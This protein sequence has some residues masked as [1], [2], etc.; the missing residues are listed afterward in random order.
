[1]MSER[2]IVPSA[3]RTPRAR[4]EEP[5]RCARGSRAA[6]STNRCHV[7]FATANLSDGWY[8]ITSP[9]ITAN[10]EAK[11]SSDEWTVPFGGGFG[12][13]F[14][15]GS[16]P[17]MNASIQGFYNVSKPGFASHWNLRAQLQL[18]FPKRR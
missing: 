1:M 18:L 17:P 6:R 3:E 14:R 5:S 15:I 8:L 7:C 11:R 12:K 4:R 13:I 2:P 16:L 9:V 10:W